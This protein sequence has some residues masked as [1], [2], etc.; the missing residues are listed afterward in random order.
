[1]S[2]KN[3]IPLLHE[4]MKVDSSIDQSR[5]PLKVYCSVNWVTLLG[6]A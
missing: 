3:Q 2:L 5:S 4:L 1:M 6:K